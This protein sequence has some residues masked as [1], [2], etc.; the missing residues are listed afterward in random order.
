MM[1]SNV[2]PGPNALY[3]NPP[4]NPQYYSPRECQ[5]T[6]LSLGVSTTVTTATANQ[7]VIGQLCRLIIPYYY[8]TYQ[9][10]GV[11]GYVID[12]PANNQVVL[13]I[14]SSEATMFI[15]SPTHVFTPAQILP[16]GDINSGPINATPQISQTYI[17][18]SFINISPA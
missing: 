1:S 7:F 15:A 8:G 3:N 17:D 11:V 2:T 13:D 6:S 14:N 16:V 12:K 5:I 10:N 9:L 18:G 4:I